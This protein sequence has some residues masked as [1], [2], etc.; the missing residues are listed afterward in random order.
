MSNKSETKSFINKLNS[1]LLKRNINYDLYLNTNE[2]K[3]TFYPSVFIK[4]Y[5]PEY[6]LDFFVKKNSIITGKNLLVK[7][8]DGVEIIDKILLSEAFILSKQNK[9]YITGTRDFA[10]LVKANS[11]E[12]KQIEN[13]L[14]EAIEESYY[15]ENK[16]MFEFTTNDIFKENAINL[17][18]NQL[19]ILYKSKN[20]IWK[21]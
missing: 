15:L 4:V 21:G 20:K 8:Y 14:W 7:I 17:K 2:N 3:M 12:L 10:Y 18:V 5:D 1:N 11:K 6:N 16:K 13:Q 9:L 19:K